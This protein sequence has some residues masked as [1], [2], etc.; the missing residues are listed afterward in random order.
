[1]AFNVTD[2]KHIDK[3]EYRLLVK[4]FFPVHNY[5]YQYEQD[6]NEFSCLMS[7]LIDYG[8]TFYI[9]D[10]SYVWISLKP[11]KEYIHSFNFLEKDF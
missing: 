1:M 8:F 10:Y 9:M 4:F 11:A 5:S 7:N 2:C 3:K 6:R